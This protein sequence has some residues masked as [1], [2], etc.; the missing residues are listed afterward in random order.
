MPE[1]HDTPARVYRW[2]DKLFGLVAVIVLFEVGVV[3]LVLP[4]TTEWGANFF[5]RLPFQLREIWNSYYFR[6]AISGLGIVDIYLSF[7]EVF[8]LRRFSAS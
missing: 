3:L 8:R 5:A 1:P 2:Y 7:V 6:G 4:W